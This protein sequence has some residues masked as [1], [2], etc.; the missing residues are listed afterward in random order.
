[1][2]RRFGDWSLLLAESTE[3][4]VGQSTRRCPDKRRKRKKKKEKDDIHTFVDDPGGLCKP[5]VV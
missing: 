5:H 2:E 1:M 4:Q 3:Q